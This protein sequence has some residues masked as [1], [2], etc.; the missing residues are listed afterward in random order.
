MAVVQLLHNFSQQ[1]Y[2]V[3]LFPLR[4]CPSMLT[5]IREK[6]SDNSKPSLSCKNKVRP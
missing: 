5:S 3:L 1:N 2:L 4:V 6:I